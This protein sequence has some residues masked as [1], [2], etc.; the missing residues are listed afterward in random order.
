MDAVPESRG[1]TQVEAARRLQRDG[2]N[3]LASAKPRSVFAIAMGVVREPMFLLLVACA[4]I[5]LF[6]GDKE[7][8]MMLASAVFVVMGITFYQER[9]TE[10]TLEA[11]RDLSSPRA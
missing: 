3:E 4:V 8:A 5:Y 6:L 10:R 11:L 9:K 2:F 1:L 7:E